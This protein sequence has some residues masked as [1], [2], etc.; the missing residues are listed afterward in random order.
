MLCPNKRANCYKRQNSEWTYIKSK[1]SL[2]PKKYRWIKKGM[3]QQTIDLKNIW[4]RHCHWVLSGDNLVHSL[5]G[6]SWKTGFFF[7]KFQYFATS[8]SPVLGC[9]WSFRK[10][11]TNSHWVENFEDLLKRFVS[12]GW[13]AVNLEK[14]QFFLNLMYQNESSRRIRPQA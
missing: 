6:C 11:V 13:V 1:S 12:E 2:V 7:E 8:P 9:Y 4:Y 5:K 14:A 10:C 3:Y